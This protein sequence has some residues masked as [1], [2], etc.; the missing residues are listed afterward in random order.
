[1][2]S[3]DCSDVQDCEVFTAIAGFKEFANLTYHCEFLYFA[4][5]CCE[6]DYFY[7][8]TSKMIEMYT[9]FYITLFTMHNSI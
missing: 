5:K 1:M 2:P 9:L 8:L 3:S 4:M 7:L 6:F